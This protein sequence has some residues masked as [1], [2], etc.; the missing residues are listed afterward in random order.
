MPIRIK[1]LEN[2]WK[3]SSKTVLDVKN[4]ILKSQTLKTK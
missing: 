3:K 2:I 4:Y 1:W